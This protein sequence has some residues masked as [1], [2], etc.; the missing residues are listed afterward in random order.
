M[1]YFLLL[2]TFIISAHVAGVCSAFAPARDICVDDCAQTEIAGPSDA[3]SGENLKFSV[4]QPSQKL[5]NVLT[6]NW[7]VSAGTIVSG[8]GTP[9]ITVDTT[10]IGGIT[11][12]VT[13]IIG[14]LPKACTKVTSCNVFGGIRCIRPLDEYGNIKFYDEQA[15]LDNYA[16]ELQNDPTTQ[17]YIMAYGG[18]VGRA[19]EAQARAERAKNYLVNKRG[20]EASRIVTVDGGYREA[21]TVALW[22]VPSGATPPQASPTVDPGEVQIVRDVKTKAHRR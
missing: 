15:R 6:Y 16:V 7:T 19:G 10:G 20:I 8:Q 17:G 12:E 3:L 9:T 13:V 1:A 2:T 11:L 4:S 14:G 22:L 5:G 21:L 18:R